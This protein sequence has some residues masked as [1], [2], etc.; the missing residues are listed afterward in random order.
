MALKKRF[1]IP[2]VFVLLLAAI[3][4]GFYLRP[5]EFFNAQVD[6]QL[7]ATGWQSRWVTVSGH[8]MRYFVTGPEN[9]PAVVLVHGLGGRAEEWRNL[10][11]YL[12]Y[13]GFRVYAPD[14]PGYGA[15]EQPADF[16][17]SVADQ[18]D[19]VVGFLNALGLQQVDLGGVS[20]GGW[21]VQLVAYHHPERVRRLIVLDSVGLHVQPEWDTRLF[22]PENGAQLEQ[23]EALLMPNPPHAPEFIVKDILRVSDKNAWVIRRALA[24][25]LTGNDVTDAMLPQLKM[26]V[27]LVWGDLDRITPLSLG[28]KMHQLIPQ[29][30]L[31]VVK[32]CGH[33]ANTQCAANYGPAVQSF[34]R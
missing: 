23:L 28:E 29:S 2:G 12:I 30:R 16:S 21:I 6:F 4:A 7:R 19:A 11:P 33:L 22:T 15:S 3:G 20:M 31:E 13:A 32:G 18:A 27:L 8:K 26:P 1:W 34:L 25:M 9:G 10:A 14:L 24:S 5:V 17:Y